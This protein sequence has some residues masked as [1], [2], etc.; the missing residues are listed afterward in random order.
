[1]IN[2]LI[3]TQRN[4]KKGYNIH[5]QF[6]DGWN[7]GFEHSKQNIL[8]SVLVWLLLTVSLLEINKNVHQEKLSLLD[9]LK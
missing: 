2:I 1:M 3:Q 7:D 4:Q 5:F 6:S 8:N 9:Y